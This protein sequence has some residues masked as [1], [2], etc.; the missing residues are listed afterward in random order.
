M[1]SDPAACSPLAGS[2]CS[3]REHKSHTSHVDHLLH[4]TWHADRSHAA[5]N[6]N[7]RG[8]QARPELAAAG[9]QPT[10]AQQVIPL[11]NNELGTF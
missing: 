1:P 5:H 9:H 8:A 3:I 11:D 2:V 10:K 4:E 7:N 6:A